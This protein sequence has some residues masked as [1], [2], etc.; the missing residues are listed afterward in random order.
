MCSVRVY[1]YGRL[2]YSAEY[3]VT[4]CRDEGGVEPYEAQTRNESEVFERSRVGYSAS[5]N[6]AVTYHQTLRS[7]LR[8]ASFAS[9]N[10]L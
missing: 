5:K 8:G 7:G 4:C 9:L 6:E 1:N 2:F 10:R 3:P